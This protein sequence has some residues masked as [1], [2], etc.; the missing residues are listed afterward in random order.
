MPDEPAPPPPS[1]QPTWL[2]GI[3][4]WAALILLLGLLAAAYLEI[5]TRVLIQTN[6]TD[7]DILSGD[8]KNNIQLT[9]RTL[10]DLTLDFTKGVSGPIKEWFPHRTDGV[11]NP[12]WP[13]IA[14]WLADKNHTP[15]GDSEV[16]PADRELFHRGRQFHLLWTLIATVLLGLAA[17]KSFSVPAALNVA[18]LVGFG[19]LLPRSAFFQ[20]EPMFYAFFL[21][22]WVAC[23]LALDRNTLWMHAVI[24][25]L[26][27]IAY[28]AK[29]SVQ[30]LLMVYI[31]ISTLRWAW[32][33]LIRRPSISSWQRH[34]HWL[35]L[36]VMALLFVLTAGPRL[37]YSARQFGDPFHSF[38]SYWMW[39]DNFE[40][41]YAW[42]AKHNS[43]AT[44]STVPKSDLPSLKNYIATHP[45]EQIQDRLL[46]GTQEKLTEFFFPK[47]TLRGTRLPKPWKGV[48]EW[49]GWYLLSL[50]GILCGLVTALKLVAPAPL[51]AAQRLHPEYFC[52]SLF[53]IGAFVGYSLAYGFYTPIGRGERFMLSLY[54][55][56]V[57]S[58]IWASES[59]VRRVRRRQEGQW[60]IPAYYTAQ[61]LLAGAIIWRLI[62]ILR[63]PIFLND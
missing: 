37:V 5:G 28:L 12:L 54:A 13:W 46:S 2:P 15:S 33:S 20:P 60:I 19:A 50:L 7:K 42:M 25:G 30:P 35:G 62:E 22:T 61:W 1:A 34:S 43:K 45:P 39:F 6:Y 31:A 3:I 24:G 57:L 48:L 59:V 9:L 27:G 40:D 18:L 49:R 53:V 63:H 52:K 26:G 23:L 14:A 51:H 32:G 58:I 17:G 8:Q 41:G 36:L 11:V 21:A 47:T 10:P 29:G 44:L 38:P 55:P 16:S 56:L 4:R